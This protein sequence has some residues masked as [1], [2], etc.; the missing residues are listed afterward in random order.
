MTTDRPDYPR[1]PIAAAVVVAIGLY[2][3]LPSEL[4]VD[5]PLIRYIVP[6]LEL[7]LILVLT[8]DAPRR[9]LLSAGLRRHFSI[10]LIALI[11]LANTAALASLLHHLLYGGGSI[12]GRTL[13]Y[14]AF[15]IWATNVIVFSLWFWELDGGGPIAR[16]KNPDGRRDFAFVQMTDPDLKY[17]GW[18]SEYFDYFYVSCTNSIAFSPTDTLPLSRMAKALMALQSALSA[19]TLLLVA[20]RAV[21]ILNT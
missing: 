10:G 7:A 6:A 16:R 8:L 18:Q 14:A 1:W 19:V 17:P 5:I 9:W 2:M 15:D 11:S 12:S 4:I 3:A 20:A 13:L 21:N